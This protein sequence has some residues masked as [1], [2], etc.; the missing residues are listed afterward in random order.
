MPYI[1]QDAKDRLANGGQPENAGELNYW[2]TLA[3]IHYIENLGL[4]Y[5]HINDVVGA[6]TGAR[7]EFYRRVAIPYEDRKANINGD[8]YPAELVGK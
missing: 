7:E 6:L 1:K 5:A 3:V 4:S 2:I 8:V